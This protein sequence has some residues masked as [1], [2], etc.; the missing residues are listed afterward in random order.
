MRAQH[1]GGRPVVVAP[2]LQ[3]S[4]RAHRTQRLV[5]PARDR[6]GGKSRPHVERRRGRA[7]LDLLDQS[8]HLRRANRRVDLLLLTVLPVG[9]DD[10][11][12]PLQL[13]GDP[14]VPGVAHR[15]QH[16]RLLVEHVHAIRAGIVHRIALCVLAD[17]LRVCARLHAS[18]LRARV[19]GFD[20]VMRDVSV[21]HEFVGITKHV[22][23]RSQVVELGCSTRARLVIE[24]DRI[25]ADVRTPHVAE[26]VFLIAG[27]LRARAAGA[28]AINQ[29]VDIP[30]ERRALQLRH[31]LS[32][33]QP[34]R[35]TER[36]RPLFMLAGAVIPLGV[37]EDLVG[38]LV[39]QLLARNP[40]D[41]FGDRCRAVTRAHRSEHR[42]GSLCELH[43]GIDRALLAAKLDRD[44]VDAHAVLDQL[45]EAER[46][47][48]RINVFALQV[49]DELHLIALGVG[50][51]SDHHRHLAEL[52]RLC[53][54]EPPVPAHQLEAATTGGRTH[55]QR[56]QHAEALNRGAQLRVGLGVSVVAH[57][58][59]DADLVELADGR[60]INGF[61]FGLRHDSSFRCFGIRRG[62]D[63][64][65]P[66]QGMKIT[67]LRAAAGS[68]AAGC[69]GGG[70]AVDALFAHCATSA[71]ARNR[72]PACAGHR[73]THARPSASSCSAASRST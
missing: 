39:A 10:T 51:L 33:D 36:E 11:C 24:A 20:V 48:D 63:P 7:G 46:L 37:I 40:S 19:I 12:D 52:R 9:P 26:Q 70:D 72:P 55:E 66:P 6:S 65:P 16:G 53:R 17:Q 2:L 30:I 71:S 41:E 18:V 69:R 3:T 4:A 47:I 57:V 43:A 34:F 13:G 29:L 44:L 27:A 8:S 61:R 45:L 23:L 64:M 68:P 1:L 14:L 35:L 73:P 5:P 25:G 60:R 21:R 56:L 54:V 28:D 42:C 49:L 38:R 50:H 32:M 58:F 67:S 31:V 22:P 62:G 59:D 15:L